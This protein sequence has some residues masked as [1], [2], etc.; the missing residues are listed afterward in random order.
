MRPWKVQL[1]DNST[2]YVRNVQEL[3]SVLDTIHA[4]NRT[5][6]IITTLESPEN[7][8]SLAIGLGA[9][10]S[11]LS[12]VAGDGDPPYLASRGDNASS[13]PIVFQFMGDWSEFP[14]KCAISLDAARAAMREFFSTGKLSDDIVWIEE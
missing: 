5:V 14:G 12:F 6:P 8:D 3:D 11:V 7:G 1:D 2:F 13:E 4:Q 9:E 10:E